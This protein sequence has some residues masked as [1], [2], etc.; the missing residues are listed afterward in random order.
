MKRSDY[1]LAALSLLML[2]WP[3]KIMLLGEAWSL[4]PA[5]N[6]IAGIC[7]GAAATANWRRGGSG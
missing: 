7:C 4:L 6:G 3:A 1:V 5:L 2:V